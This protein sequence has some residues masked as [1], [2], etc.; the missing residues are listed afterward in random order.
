MYELVYFFPEL[1]NHLTMAPKL[2]KLDKSLCFFELDGNEATRIL[3]YMLDSNPY[4]KGPLVL[5]YVLPLLGLFSLRYTSRFIEGYCLVQDNKQL[6]LRN[7]EGYWN[8]GVK[9]KET[10]L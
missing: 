1:I 8:G 6:S 7:S 10:K 4:N 2:R 3:R 9:R 5:L